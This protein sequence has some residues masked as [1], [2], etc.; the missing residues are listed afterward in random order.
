M[1]SEIL[2]LLHIMIILKLTSSY[3]SVCAVRRDFLL[4]AR[5]SA[6]Q[7]ILFLQ[8]L[9]APPPDYV[10]GNERKIILPVLWE[11][12]DVGFVLIIDFAERWSLI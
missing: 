7:W 8:I 11:K 9:S 3:L 5:F 6:Y 12:I 1:E 4:D 10:N 2:F